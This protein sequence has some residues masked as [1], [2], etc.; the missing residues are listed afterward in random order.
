MDMDMDMDKDMDLEMKSIFPQEQPECWLDIL[1]TQ[2]RWGSRLPRLAPTGAP[3]TACS[4][5]WGRRTRAHAWIFL[6]VRSQEGWDAWTVQGHD[7]PSL[8]GGWHKRRH[9]RGQCPG[10]FNLILQP[11]ANK[12]HSCLFS[13]GPKEASKSGQ[14]LF[15]NNCRSFCR[16]HPGRFSC[17]WWKINNKLGL[18]HFN[19][20]QNQFKM[21]WFPV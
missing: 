19:L 8:G 13:P 21:K 12:N 1:W 18:T 10:E 16:T 5:A 11:F 4:T 20:S 14:H 3:S 17:F 9:L 2:W 6:A 15:N 7:I